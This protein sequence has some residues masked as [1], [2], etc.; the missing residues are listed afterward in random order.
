MK[1]EINLLTAH[2]Q[3]AM[4]KNF[5]TFKLFEELVVGDVFK[6]SPTLDNDIPKK[7]YTVYFKDNVTTKINATY[8]KDLNKMEIPNS[9][10]REVMVFPGR[11]CTQ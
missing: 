9:V 11:S 1:V 7:F 2:Q 8:G 3:K 5:F 6:F 10:T 4:N